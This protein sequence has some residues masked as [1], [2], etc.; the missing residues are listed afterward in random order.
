MFDVHRGHRGCLPE[1]MP[2]LRQVTLKVPAVCSQLVND[3]W[4]MVQRCDDMRCEHAHTLYLT[5]HGLLGTPPLGRVVSHLEMNPR[6]EVGEFLHL[7][8]AAPTCIL[9]HT[10]VG[11]LG[12][13]RSEHRELFLLACRQKGK[14]AFHF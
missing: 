12:Q 1:E 6:Q 10:Q 3:S 7:L 2:P 9:R 8:Y 5:E 13:E 4:S 14:Y 11:E